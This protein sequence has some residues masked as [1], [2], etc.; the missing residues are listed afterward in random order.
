[1]RYILPLLALAIAIPAAANA[2]PPG[3]AKKNKDAKHYEKNHDHHDHDVDA[4]DVILDTVFTALERELIGD[5]YSSN[6]GGRYDR[7]GLPPG[8]QKQLDRNGRLPPGLEGRALPPG[9]AKKLPYREGTYRRVIDNDVYLIQ[10]GTNL[11]LDI[12][13][14]VI[15]DN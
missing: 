8:L 15:R 4:G 6:Y 5:Y 11:I 1:M 9:L 7:G 14:D 13:R 3:H 2:Q 10:R 12:I